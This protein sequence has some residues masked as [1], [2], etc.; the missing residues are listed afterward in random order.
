MVSQTITHWKFT[1]A[2][3]STLALV[4]LWALLVLGALWLAAQWASRYALRDLRG[5]AAHTL[6]LIAEN[7]KGEVARFRIQPE[8]LASNPIFASALQ[9]GDQESIRAANAELQR[10]N[11][12]SGALD[13]YLMDA[14]GKTLAAS[15]WAS[16]R[17][18]VGLNFS[19]RPYFQDA[20]QGQ[21]GRFLALGTTSDERGYYFAFPVLV[22]AKIVGVIV[23]KMPVSHFE[24]Q[25]SGLG[26]DVIV[27]DEN[28]VVFLSTR[29][30]WVYRAVLP[31]SEAQLAQIRSNKK[32][33]YIAVNELPIV[34]RTP[35]ASAGELMIIGSTDAKSGAATEYL[36]E[37]A[38]LPE[39]EW[40]VLLL[41]RTDVVDGRVR[42]AA[43][44][45]GGA[46]LGLGLTAGLLWQRRRRRQEAMD[47]QRRNH[48]ELERR[49][50]SRT[51]ELQIAN[52]RLQSEVLEREKAEQVLRRTQANLIQAAKLA[53]LGQISAG[54]SHELNQP[55]AAVR[56]YADNAR[57]FLERDQRDTAL[58]N[59]GEISQ[60]TERM[61]R[62]I[63]HLRTYARDEAVEAR[64]TSVV[65]ALQAALDLLDARIKSDAVSIAQ[66]LPA[67]DVS[68]MAGDVRLQQVFVNLATN[69]LD[70]MRTA[71]K[72]HLEV[73]VEKQPQSVRIIFRDTGSGIAEK[74]LTQIFDPFFSTQ[75]TGSG[76][77]LGLSISDSI[78]RQ[79]RGKIEAGNIETG[80]AQFTV[81]LPRADGVGA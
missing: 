55:L 56:S 34:K 13:T 48:E 71:P 3:R 79:F 51:S 24:A 45:A 70:A 42:G 62:I 32:Y 28:N 47:L 8:L 17:T 15:N 57:A 29:R 68:V 23:V 80:G 75:P 60:L 10:I 26:H 11:Q 43:L 9:S 16:S 77:G 49:V 31:L 40:R 52:Q 14:A 6:S 18:F 25:W 2:R 7:L 78:I 5:N 54:I 39:T 20:M 61:A 81:I 65:G 36:V 38:S 46:M 74:N 58:S 33:S 4:A 53:A 76:L 50:Q 72:K 63:R 12:A 21:L 44:L 19:Y 73:V 27:I 30:Q 41:A 66:H 22:G 67:G 35:D 69:A 37:S 1:R 64:P 59:L